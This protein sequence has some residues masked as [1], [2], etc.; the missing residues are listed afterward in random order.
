MRRAAAPAVPDKQPVAYPVPEEVVR[1]NSDA[2]TLGAMLEDP[3]R[4]T[5]LVISWPKS[6]WKAHAGVEMP[7]EG[8]VFGLE[9]F[10]TAPR[11]DGQIQASFRLVLLG[12]GARR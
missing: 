2:P 9:V 11:A 3:E 10:R 12:D 4:F 7:I 6:F 8:D 1:L 5:P